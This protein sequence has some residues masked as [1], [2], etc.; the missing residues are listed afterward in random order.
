MKNLYIYLLFIVF[1][2]GCKKGTPIA[3]KD[4]IVDVA[5]L[6]DFKLEAK[7]NVNVINNDIS[8]EINGDEIRAVI[9]GTATSK[10]LLVVT[11]NANNIK[12]M[13]NGVDQKSGKTLNDF[14]K[15]ITYEV[16]FANG[17]KKT[18]Q[19][20]VVDFTGLPIFH[21]TTEAPVTSKDNYVK[22]NLTINANT[23]FKQE[24]GAISLEMKGRGNSTWGLPK[25]PYRLKLDNKASI[26]G[27]AAAKNW[28]LLANYSDKTLMRTS[29]A[30]EL[31]QSLGTDFTPNAIPVEVVL[32]GVYLGSY[33]LTE[34][35][36]VNKGRVDITELKTGDITT[37][38]ISGGYLLEVDE[39]LD[40]DFW[41]RTNK[42]LPFNIKSPKDINQTQLNYIRNYIQ[43]TENAIFATNFADPQNGYAKYINVNSFINWYLVQE[44]V[45]NQ[46]ARKYSSIFYYKDRNGKLGM[47][48]L[49]DFDL[50]IGNVNY[51]EAIGPRGWWVKNGTWFNRLFDDPAF[52]QKVRARWDEIKNKEIAK[53]LD[54]IDNRASY[55]ELSQ[56]ENFKRWDILNE[57][58]WPN[59]QI[60]GSYEAEVKQIKEWLKI[61]ITWLDENL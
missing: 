37:D 11:F 25:K 48:P 3:E 27:L 35:V 24:E 28:V 43:D 58:V 26:L 9:P 30:F 31:G 14:S 21:L 8:C 40:E 7:N 60:L 56:R 12:V 44:L 10:K 23:Q 34:Q 16:F 19:F 57:Q 17:A 29:F 50:A 52:K 59:P 45:K 61:R 54:N 33:L 15:P 51:S 53:A 47:G 42:K 13:V 36:E 38:K 55:L 32:N 1:I 46:D 22:G 41:F 39:R 6:A 2:V 5:A 49:W 20:K 18:Y 4:H